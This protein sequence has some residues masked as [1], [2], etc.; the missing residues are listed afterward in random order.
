ME[1]YYNIHFGC[2]H[3]HDCESCPY[4]D[5]VDGTFFEAWEGVK[6]KAQAMLRQGKKPKEIGKVLAISQSS[7]CRYRKEMT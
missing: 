5:C 2:K 4:D 7:I 1:S 6:Q 3:Y